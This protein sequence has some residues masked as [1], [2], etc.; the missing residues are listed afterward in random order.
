MASLSQKRPSLPP[1]ADGLSPAPSVGWLSRLARRVWVGS[2]L[3]ALGGLGSVVLAGA[4]EA[5]RVANTG[6]QERNPD[7]VK[8]AL[9]F[10]FLRYV[11]WDEGRFPDRKSPLLVGI[12]GEGDVAKTLSRVLE[13]KKHGRRPVQVKR[14]LQPEDV[15]D[16]HVLYLTASVD[17]VKTVPKVLERVSAQGVFVVAE[18]DEMARRGAVLNFYLEQ[19][20]GSGHVRF[21]INPDESKRRDLKISASL[22]KLAKIIRDEKKGRMAQPPSSTVLAG[23][24]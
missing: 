24:R 5:R 8:A 22:L 11:E 9:L 12:V 20:G 18:R 6:D 16:C 15:Q 2:L 23:G 19:R 3:L 1:E 13:G 21:E 7:E 14:Y 10:K 4:L 17:P